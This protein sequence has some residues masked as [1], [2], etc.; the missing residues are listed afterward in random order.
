[1]RN[2]NRFDVGLERGLG[3]EVVQRRGFMTIALLPATLSTL[4]KQLAELRTE[5]SG[6]YVEKGCLFT[7]GRR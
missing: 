4:A 3:W 5:I 7:D 2:R 1:M 6:C